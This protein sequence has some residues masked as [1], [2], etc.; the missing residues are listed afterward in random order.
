MDALGQK[1]RQARREAGYKNA[2]LF[3]VRLGVGIRTVN[4]WETGETTPTILKLREIAAATDKTL[5]YFLAD[6]MAA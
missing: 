2:E 1:I 3:A 6:E 4:R 5:A